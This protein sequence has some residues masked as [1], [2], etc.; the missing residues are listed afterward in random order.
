MNTYVQGICLTIVPCNSDNAAR[1]PIQSVA[2]TG[3]DKQPGPSAPTIKPS[4]TDENGL[5]WMATTY[6]ATKLAI[7]L[8]KESADVFPPLKSVVGGLSAIL[9]HCDVRYLSRSALPTILIAVLAN[10]GVSQNN[11]I[12]DASS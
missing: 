8:V 12:F 5:N 2:G 9:D 4:T 11:R 1:D 6:S 10:G 3:Q 7:N